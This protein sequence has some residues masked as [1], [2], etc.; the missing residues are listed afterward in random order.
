MNLIKEENGGF[1]SHI[2]TKLQETLKNIKIC[3]L[4][5][6][7][8]NSNKNYS[9]IQYFDAH[10]K[11]YTENTFNID[12]SLTYLINIDINPEF[13]VEIQDISLS[14]GRISASQKQVLQ[15]IIQSKLTNFNDEMRIKSIENNTNG[16]PIVLFD[17]FITKNNSIISFMIEIEK[18]LDEYLFNILK[19]REI[20]RNNFKNNLENENSKNT[21][22]N[23]RI[24]SSTEYLNDIL[25]PHIP[26]HLDAHLIKKTA[27]C[28]QSLAVVL[29]KTIK[30]LKE[31]I[32]ST[33]RR[34]IAI[35]EVF[36]SSLNNFIEYL[37]YVRF[38]SFNLLFKLFKILKSIH[39]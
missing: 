38:F 36:P 35:D 32:H 25:L 23:H 28:T 9:Y 33:T 30:V 12:A 10:L 17:Q 20:I 21:Q 26:V 18:F 5:T 3:L 4:Y 7:P 34:V 37:S 39:Q 27:T 14:C 19:K 11:D 16:Q 22:I 31:S 2:E 24:L 13:F 6:T 29:K 8:D 15:F 1:A